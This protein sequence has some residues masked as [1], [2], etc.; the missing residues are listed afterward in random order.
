MQIDDAGEGQ[1]E[2]LD[3]DLR[4]QLTLTTA[5]LRFGDYLVRNIASDTGDVFVDATSI[6]LF[7]LRFIHTPH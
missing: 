1:I 2:I 6:L 3:A 7:P 5:D 4:R